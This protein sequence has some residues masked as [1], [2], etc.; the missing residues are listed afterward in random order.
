M[1]KPPL[2]T[3]Q[4]V[5]IPLDKLRGHLCRAMTEVSTL[6]YFDLEATGLKSA[7][8]PRICELSFLAVNIQDMLD[9]NLILM[10]SIKSRKI[11][12]N[13]LQARN[14]LPRI[15]NK[16][17]LCVYPMATIVPVVS[18]ITGLDNYN[19]IGQSKFSKN[20]GDLINSFL[21]LLPSPVCLVAH[22][23]NGYDFPLLKAELEKVNTQ[24]TPDI[25]CIDSYIGI[26]EIFKKRKE[27]IKLEIVKEVDLNEERKMLKME[28]NAAT[29]LIN[30]GVFETEMIE[31]TINEISFS[32]AE[33]EVTPKSV[34]YNSNMNFTPRK[35]KLSSSS[36]CVEKSRKNLKFVN[37]G[38]PTSF[39][40]VNLH[41]HLFGCQPEQ[42][43]GAEVDCLSLMKTTAALGDE[44]IDWVKG[45][46]FKF[47]TCK[48]M[49][50]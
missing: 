21:S 37:P 18:D 42:S 50:G 20:T 19:L 23:G 38:E 30:A 2:L 46:C 49:W 17:T 12:N 33:N 45:N 14:L 29:D 11:D 16:L 31:G 15:V 5:R 13:L 8:K 3:R 41:K 36:E 7:G 39:S 27:V 22:N 32:K 25:L 40:L 35:H 48:K 26:K 4:T 24:L 9:M 47:E 43:H 6:V 34:K 1:D 28:L 10:K 44:W